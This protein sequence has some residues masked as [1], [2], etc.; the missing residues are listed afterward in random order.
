MTQS[1]TVGWEV[2]DKNGKINISTQSPNSGVVIIR[3]N[4]PATSSIPKITIG[5][6][7]NPSTPKKIPSNTPKLIFACRT[8]E[9]PFLLKP[10]KSKN[11][12]PMIKLFSNKDCIDILDK[13]KGMENPTH[14]IAQI[15]VVVSV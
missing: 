5:D 11:I 12:F 13:S 6:T 15:S 14:T 7:K 3:S 9:S 4:I 1:K 10:K 2:K 8:V